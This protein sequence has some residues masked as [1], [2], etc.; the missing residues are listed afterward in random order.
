MVI[1]EIS[2][3]FS[4]ASLDLYKYS[5]IQF[6]QNQVEATIS[7]LVMGVALCDASL[8]SSLAMIAWLCRQLRR[9]IQL[10]YLN[11]PR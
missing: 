3:S 6:L 5:P 11:Q 4:K 1:K 8:S 10:Q 7:L 2:A 9:M